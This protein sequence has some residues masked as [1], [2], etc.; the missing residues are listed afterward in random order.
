MEHDRPSSAV[1]MPNTAYINSSANGTTLLYELQ[2][3][4]VTKTYGAVILHQP[5]VPHEA[6]HRR[7]DMFRLAN[8]TLHFGTKE[9]KRNF[10]CPMRL[11]SP[12]GTMK[13]RAPAP[14]R[15]KWR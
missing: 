14:G 4:N 13:D 11:R 6:L 5:P 12:Y 7:R 10:T 2:T 3:N 15:A 1:N 8:T 9:D